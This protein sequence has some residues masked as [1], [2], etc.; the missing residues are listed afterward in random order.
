MLL[1]NAKGRLMGSDAPLLSRPRGELTQAGSPAP[2]SSALKPC[3][4]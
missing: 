4:A 2:S 1:P 3:T